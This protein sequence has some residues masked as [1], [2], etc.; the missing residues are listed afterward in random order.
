LSKRLLAAQSLLLFVLFL[1][2]SGC[3]NH[4][5][6]SSATAIL[7]DRVPNA[8]IGGPDKLDTL[9][10]HVKG[11]QPGQQ[12]VLY[13]KSQELWWIQPFSD[14]PYTK[15]QGSKW[16]SQ[17]HL[18]TEYAALLINQGYKPPRTTEN[19]P[20][21]GAGIAAIAVVKGKGEVPNPP[22]SKI[23]HF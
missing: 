10:G 18:G 11:V 13:A 3:H 16:S 6:N 14:R 1:L 21:P 4:S 23:L 5:S 15:I 22:P 2:L 19:L 8:D 7:F 9:E 20:A 17:I 12:I